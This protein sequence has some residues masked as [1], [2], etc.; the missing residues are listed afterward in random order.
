MLYAWEKIYDCG[1]KINV[2]LFGVFFIGQKLKLYKVFAKTKQLRKNGHP[3]VHT[4]SKKHDNTGNIY[5]KTF[6]YFTNT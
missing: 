2:Y 6:A 4:V 5:T 3:I 1:T